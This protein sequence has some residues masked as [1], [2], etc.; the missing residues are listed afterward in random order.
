ML[1]FLGVT[2]LGCVV[3]EEIAKTATPYPLSTCV[4]SGEKLGLMGPPF[5]IQHQGTEVHFCCE[6]CVKD[7]NQDP[8]KYLNRLRSGSQ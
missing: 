2:H 4:V 6:G 1:L 3:A 5:I 8:E 7:F